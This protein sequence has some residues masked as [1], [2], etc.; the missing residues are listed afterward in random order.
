[1]ENLDALVSQALEAVQ[2][3]EDINALEQL[4]VQYLGKKGELTA[5]MQTLGKLSAEER[6]K[7]GALINT[8]KSQVQDALNARKSVLEQALLAEKL[9][10]ERID[11]TLPGRGQASG[12][13]HPVTRTLERVEQFFTHIGYS[14][15]EGP[16]VE[17]DYHNFEALN[18]PGH[19]PARAMHDTF[20]FNANMLLRTHTSPVQ[21][22]TM[23]SQ[24]PPIRIVCP[25]RVYRCDSDI[26]HS[27]MFHQVEGLLV[28]EGISF[29]DLK[30]TIEEFLR[31][32][33]EKP[34][35]VRFRP[36]FFPFTE[37]SAEVDMQ[38]VMCSGKGCRVCKQTGW[39]EVMGCGMVHP[40]VLRMSGSDPEKYSGF[41][42]GMGVERLA[43]LRYG[44]NDL[45]L[46][47]D[48]DL[49]FLAQFR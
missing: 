10:S 28:D 27:P 18:I 45:R 37:P 22:R 44:V 16:E 14:V 7:A 20:Y 30:G 25:G 49:R 5:L 17:D 39:L 42:F 11:V 32:F 33:F 46:F 21:V 38:C 23:E 2:Q 9:A 29:A 15:A 4:R 3:S 1:M 6:P 34:L 26:T 31:V 47:F 40:N 43:M 12:G 48:N 36:S 24:Q 8:A 13:L 35:G 19:H 41:A